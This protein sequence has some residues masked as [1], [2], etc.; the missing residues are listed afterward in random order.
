MF[1][2]RMPLIL[3]A[4]ALLA[5]AT[6]AS[7][8]V[9]IKT[10]AGGADCEMR[11][12]NQSTDLFG[13]VVPGY[14]RGAATEAAT[15]ENY[16]NPYPTPGSLNSSVSY[17]KF[18]ISGLPEIGDAFWTSNQQAVFR[19]HVANTNLVRNSRLEAL[20]PGATSASTNSKDWSYGTSNLGAADSAV[21]M[22][23]A[24]Y[25]LDPNGVYANDPGGTGLRTDRSGNVYASTQDKYEWTEGVGTGAA[26]DVSGITFYDAPG[27]TPHCM[28]SGSCDTAEYGGVATDVAQSK[29]HIDDLN[30]NAQLLGTWTWPMV[31]PMNHLPIGMAMDFSSPAL[32][33]LVQ[34]AKLAG[35]ESVTLIVAANMDEYMDGAP[36]TASPWRLPSSFFGFNYI[37]NPKEKL[38]LPADTAYDPDV[39][40]SPPDSQTSQYSAASNATGR[41]S[42][43][44]ILRVPEPSSLL[45]IG[46]GL[47]ALAFARRK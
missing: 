4:V 15:R 7:A 13:A 22:Q 38:T 31:N 46:L 47:A 41:F 11:E 19:A 23:F 36:A 12:E 39:F 2:R 45:L 9:V 43:A 3:A 5:W 17:F 10:N 25:G 28:L 42:P 21:Q 14:N 1:T 8:N 16:L 30:S 34:A 32:M 40:N 6:V 29:G 44:L 35:R 33:S 24:V 37:I 20:R 26:T 27:I 18:D